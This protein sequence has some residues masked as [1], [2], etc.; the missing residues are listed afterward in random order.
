MTK[1]SIGSI[2]SFPVLQVKNISTFMHDVLPSDIL[3]A[4]VTKNTLGQTFYSVAGF[5]LCNNLAKKAWTLSIIFE[6]RGSVQ[7]LVIFCN[8]L[9]YR[10]N[11]QLFKGGGQSVSTSQLLASV[12]HFLLFVLSCDIINRILSGD[13][14]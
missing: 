7:C 8:S 5:S 3:G 4:L 2:S 1:T 9:L 6:A 10:A 14:T 12:R 13:R 11:S